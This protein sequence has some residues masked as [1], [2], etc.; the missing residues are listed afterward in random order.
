M[1]FSNYGKTKYG[2][3]LDGIENVTISNET[4]DGV[5]SII[6]GVDG[7]S[8]VTY[9]LSGKI[10]NLTILVAKGTD[11]K[12]ILELEK[13]VLEK[14]KSEEL[15]YYDFQMLIDSVEEDS[16][17]PIIGSKSKNNESFSWTG[18]VVEDEE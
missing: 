16:N 13:P 9:H 8:D 17:Y 2:N 5:K 14:F 1:L 3:R 4:I 18:Q 6:K 11:S 12:K 7:V 10:V 15:A